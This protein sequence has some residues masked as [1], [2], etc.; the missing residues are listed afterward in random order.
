[1]SEKDIIISRPKKNELPEILDFFEAVLKDTFLTNGLSK[2]Q[3]LLQEEIIDKK[4]YIMQD[5]DSNG[6]KRYFL[7]AKSENEIIGCMEYGLSNELLKNC[8]NHAMDDLYEIGTMFIL[9]KYQKEGISIL[10]QKQIFKALTEIGETECCFDSG[11]PIAQKIWTK[12]FGKPTF[13]LKDFWGEG[14]PHMV[15]RIDIKKVLETL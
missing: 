5:F 15:W 7:F 3:D 6:E 2:M 1:M 8:T 11:Y 4:R 14:A 10:L 12:R 13:Y 9:P